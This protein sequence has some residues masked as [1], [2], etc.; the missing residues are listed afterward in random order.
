MKK[1]LVDGTEVNLVKEIEG[2]YLYRHVYYDHEYYEEIEH[3]DTMFTEKLFDEPPV[4]KIHSK[5]KELEEAKEK[6]Q[7]ELNDLRAKKSKEKDLLTDIKN[8]DFMQCVVDYMNGNFS[9]VLYLNDCDIMPKENVHISS[10]IK[11]INTKHGFNLY[12]LRDSSYESYDDRPIMVFKSEAKAVTFAKKYLTSQLRKNTEKDNYPWGGKAIKNWFKDI[13]YS[14]AK[15][16]EKDSE[17]MNFYKAKL[18]EAEERE[19][20]KTREKLEKEIE[21]KTKKLKDIS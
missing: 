3:S 14:T 19:N 15:E 8:R 17:F 12:I 10:Y 4:E 7:Q 5:V 11:L 1:Y 9:H 18:K 13:R 6:A 16:L 21:E 2:G 20:K